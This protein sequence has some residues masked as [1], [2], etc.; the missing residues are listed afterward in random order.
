MIA[1]RMGASALRRGA[2]LRPNVFFTQNAPRVIASSLCT[3]APMRA[4]A[5]E[6]LTESDEATRL[7]A[8]RKLRPLSPHLEIYRPEQTWFGASI[9]TRITGGALAGTLYVYAAAYLLSPLAGWHI[10]SSALVAAFAAMPLVV[11]GAVKSVV[12]WPF[13]YH[14]LNGIRHLSYDYT[15]GFSRADISRWAKVITGSSFVVAL[16]LGFLW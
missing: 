2:A 8:Q 9:W 10:E 13:A 7:A 4:A 16:G 1:P 6:K 5:T 14:A 12:A 3:S 15:V 11:K